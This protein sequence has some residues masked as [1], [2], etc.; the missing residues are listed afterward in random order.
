MSWKGARGAVG[1][2]R[3]RAE[4]CGTASPPLPA[5]S[6]HT[7]AERERRRPAPAAP[8]RQ[9]GTCSDEQLSDAIAGALPRSVEDKRSATSA[10]AR[11]GPSPD[12]CE[13]GVT[14]GARRRASFQQQCAKSSSALRPVVR[15]DASQRLGERYHNGCGGAETDDAAGGAAIPHSTAR[16]LGAK[17]CGS[18]CRGTAA[19]IPHSTTRRLGAKAC[20]FCCRGT[21]T[22]IP[23]STTRRLGTK[24]CGFCCRGTAAAI[25]H[26]TT[27]RLGTK[28]CGSC[29]RGTA[30]AI[31]HC[32][33]RRLGTEACGSC[34]R[35]TA[36][37]IPHSTTRRLGTKACGSCCRGTAL[38]GW[39]DHRRPA[40]CRRQH[41]QQCHHLAVQHSY[42]VL[43]SR[44]SEC[45]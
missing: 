11:G 6:P 22:A 43:I 1:A 13:G 39:N 15:A 40:V 37:A 44:V 29:C 17:A 28:A 20:G 38:P 23:H 31:P 3:G 35:G 8:W 19:A 41:T 33:T 25:P 42:R 27:R 26:S 18:C 4:G 16:R 9:R 2:R 34:C 45:A 7:E 24:A 14:C 30:A 10:S 5:P 21:A 12:F 36:A 32:T